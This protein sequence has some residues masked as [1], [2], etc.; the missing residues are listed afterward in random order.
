LNQ[1]DTWLHS[2]K[3]ASTVKLAFFLEKYWCTKITF[4][5]Q[6]IT[7]PSLGIPHMELFSNLGLSGFKAI[8]SKTFASTNAAPM[9]IKAAV[10]EV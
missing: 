8:A 7:S 6:E 9:V 4:S 10:D 2:V 3:N 1:P 5:L